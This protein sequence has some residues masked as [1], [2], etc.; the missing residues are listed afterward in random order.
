MDE[1]EP[2]YDDLSVQPRTLTKSRHHKNVFWLAGRCAS[3]NVESDIM[4]VTSAVEEDEMTRV[5]KS[6]FG[7]S[8]TTDA[9][10]LKGATGVVKDVALRAGVDMDK[11][12]YTALVKWLLPR[13]KRAKPPVKVL[14]YGMPV[15]QDE[16][17]RVKP[18]IIVCMGKHV[19]D[20]LSDRKIGFDDA[21][22]AWFWSDEYK[23]HLY[24]TYTPYVLA[25]RPELYE[26]FRIDFQEIAR[27][28]D[29]I[30]GVGVD[31]VPAR[32]TVLKDE[33]S[34]RSWVLQ[35][36]IEQHHLYA[37][38]CEWHGKQHY[39]ADLRSIQMAWTESD[40]MVTLFRNEKNQWAFEF[41]PETEARVKANAEQ[42]YARRSAEGIP[43]TYEKELKV[44]RYRAAGE[45]IEPIIADP[46]TELIGHHFSADA[47]MIEHWLGIDTYQ[48]CVLDTEFAQQT[49]D[50][51]SELDL[52]RGIA[53]KYTTLGFYS[54]DLIEWKRANR[55]LCADGYGFIPESIMLPGGFS[56]T[57]SRHVG[58]SEQPWSGADL[59]RIPTGRY[60]DYL[61]PPWTWLMCGVW[62]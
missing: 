48:K 6:L 43:T 56:G 34:L 11:S 60:R 28:R 58:F 52:E 38:D 57:H 49:V 35:M 36:R 21:H 26:T 41:L 59:R 47:V 24:V 10:Y 61:P 18:K 31:D 33:A 2:D 32:W 40:S 20:Q 53:M 39:D 17:R 46:Q 29:I 42:A 27:K 37:V 25:S 30:N 22:G 62:G 13:S 50:E 45:I 54:Q 7:Y 51:S 8:I 15:L 3:E 55:K 14:K 12:Y 4:F 5:K 9:E 16:I 44:A 1:L 23:A 19:F